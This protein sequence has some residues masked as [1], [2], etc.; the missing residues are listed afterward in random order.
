M[1]LK[2]DEIVESTEHKQVL[3][4]VIGHNSRLK[5][6]NQDTYQEVLEIPCIFPARLIPMLEIAGLI[7][8]RHDP[9]VVQVTLQILLLRIR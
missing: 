9:Q 4:C 1:C 8:W 3:W 7:E 5:Q 2:F 6:Y